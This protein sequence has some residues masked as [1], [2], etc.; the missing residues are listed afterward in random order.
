[1]EIKAQTNTFEGGM[2]MDT[3]AVLL[4]GNKYR[5]A[6]NIRL[7]ADNSS[8]GGVL[9]NIEDVR[10]YEGGLSDDETILGTAVTYWYNK[11]TK[12]VQQV[13]VVITKEVYNNININNIYII[14]NF[15]SI[16]PTWKLI[17]TVEQ[18]W[19][20]KVSLVTNY[21]KQT[22][23]NLYIANHEQEM[24]CVNLQTDYN[25]TK[26][27]PLENVEN[28]NIQPRGVLFQPQVDKIINGSLTGGLYQYVCQLYQLNG[29]N[30][31]YSV[32]SEQIRLA[33]SAETEGQSFKGDAKFDTTN[34]G[35]SISCKC[36]TGKCDR[37][38]FIRVYYTSN[39]GVPTCEII[40]EITVT[41]SET[42]QTF[43]L[44]DGGIAAISTVTVNELNE[45]TNIFKA[46]SII[47][48]KN[49][50]FAS[51]IEQYQFDVDYDARAYRCNTKGYVKL[52][53]PE[54]EINCKLTDILSGAV[55]V[56]TEC[57]CQNPLNTRLTYAE[58]NTDTEYAFQSNGTVRG[59]EGLN[60]KY[61]FI[62]GTLCEDDSQVTNDGPLNVPA[63]NVT[64]DPKAYSLSSMTLTNPESDT[65]Y[66]MAVDSEARQWNARSSYVCNKFTGY[67]RDGIY[68]FGIV[69]CNEIG[70]RSPVHWIGDIRFPARNITGYEAFECGG[71]FAGKKVALLSKP[72]GIRFTVNNIPA[73]VKSYHIVRVNRTLNDRNVVT[74]GLLSKTVAFNGWWAWDNGDDK[75]Q[76]LA[77]TNDR[78]PT[79]FPSF[80][81]RIGDTDSVYVWDQDVKVD[82]DHIEVTPKEVKKPSNIYPVCAAVFDN[83]LTRPH[84]SEG[85]SVLPR[86]NYMDD[87][88]VYTFVSADLCFNRQNMT[89]VVKKGMHIVPLSLVDGRT[90][91]EVNGKYRSHG[92]QLDSD[93]ISSN[94]HDFSDRNTMTHGFI[95]E[96]FPVGIPNHDDNAYVFAG[97]GG[98]ADKGVT[99]NVAK[100][101]NF[102]S[103]I[104]AQN[105]TGD[106]T[107]NN[108]RKFD[109][110]NYSAIINNC[111]SSTYIGLDVI[112]N[113]GLDDYVEELKL[114]KNY[115]QVLDK[116]YF[117]N[118]NVSSK[119]E[120]GIGG[121]SLAIYSPELQK[122][123]PGTTL[124]A[125]YDYLNAA[126]CPLV[127]NIV[128]NTTPYGGYTYNAIT[129]TTY[130]IVTKSNSAETQDNF[131]FGGDT[132]LNV[133][134]YVHNYR[135]N[136]NDPER[137][138]GA[139]TFTAYYL[140]VETIVNTYYRNDDHFSQQAKCSN[141]SPTAFTG[142]YAPISYGLNAG[143]ASDTGY[144]QQHNQY[145]I[146]SSYNAAP[147]LFKYVSQAKDTDL[148]SYRRNTIISS[149]LK[150]TGEKSDSWRVFKFAN[151]LDVDADYGQVTNL[152]IFQDKLY[153]FQ[154][155]A[156]GIASV[157][158]RSLITDANHNQVTL[159]TGDVLARF[160]YLITKNG[161][162][163]INDK[164]IVASDSTMY[165]YDFDKNVL[166]AIGNGFSE[167]SK[168][169][170][171][172]SYFNRLPDKGRNNPVSFYDKKY[173]EVWFKIYDRSLIYNEQL[174]CFTSFYTHNPNWFLPFSD[175][176]ITIK[177]NNCYYLHNM[178]DVDSAEKEERIS[179]I[180]FI[181]NQ[182]APQTKAFDNQWFEAELK[183]KTDSNRPEII[184]NVY[185]ETKTQETE[186][187]DYTNIENR[188]DTYRF[189]IGREKQSNPELQKQ[190]NMSFAGRMRGKYLI[191]N[192][193]FDCNDN[194]EFKLPY[195]T[196]TYRY[197][198][199]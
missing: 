77:Y 139:R 111:I 185:F 145:L 43:T 130:S 50:L 134:D 93:N 194:R 82:W 105:Y 71:V 25:T 100:Y 148:Y 47:K 22:V 17:L 92:T 44:D 42:E 58:E 87:S 177:D 112:R 128:K 59:G 90:I 172:Q 151:Y 21:E 80:F 168:A 35:V 167:I 7:L 5:E 89:S 36:I 117:I 188:E 152:K 98:W 181:V 20:D 57:Y 34:K 126:F 182:D 132:Y 103:K 124:S 46:N 115:G 163:I 26:D 12:Q 137:M 180:K 109:T 175:K 192:Y 150:T 122:V 74:Q 183:D 75:D 65:K 56:P 104:Y 120:I 70:Q 141:Y 69:F 62:T 198:L 146:N 16:K 187:I 170:H 144:I 155:S 49:R 4:Q 24:K 110:K 106:D 78:R 6:Q 191:C 15:E 113:S 159:G 176:L 18:Q 64:L 125:T 72:L 2:D 190:T 199:I 121:P 73:G 158:E 31:I 53:D 118:S 19:D 40:S 173:N 88:G 23:C 179:K 61:E 186:P 33:N 68:R 1:M 39:T 67:Q 178:Y 114:L 154:D 8:T 41:P 129:N 84:L 9:Q 86:V 30:S 184:K 51:N 3:D 136:R 138:S 174:Q 195:I 38:R 101:Y 91:T 27:N 116:F 161:D 79:V 52:E 10:Q 37:L 66:T 140:P 119:H 162:S 94:G 13:G 156:V 197:S 55:V 153:F 133:F 169:K 107:R 171:V 166:C 165:W 76:Q 127:V 164:S 142:Q 99:G 29:G 32:P 96:Y 45:L 48:F 63:R 135:I 149:E 97:T 143:E 108:P 81:R 85:D 60:I 83:G 196:T 11:D 14:Y 123:C 193:T 54:N 131:C 102:Y 95:A 189:P 147:T 157:N 160:D 28:I